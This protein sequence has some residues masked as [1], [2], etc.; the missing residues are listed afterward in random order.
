MNVDAMMREARDAQRH[1]EGGTGE[2]K[3]PATQ[4]GTICDLRL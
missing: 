4:F 3:E 1:E 2:G